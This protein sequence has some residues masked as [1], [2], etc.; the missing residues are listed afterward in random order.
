MLFC[1]CLQ[2]NRFSNSIL[3]PFRETPSNPTFLTLDYNDIIKN[4]ELIIQVASKAVVN[5]VIFWLTP[6]Q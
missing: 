3:W 1:S 5:Y 2:F 6:F 4:G